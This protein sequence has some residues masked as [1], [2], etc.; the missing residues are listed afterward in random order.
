MIDFFTFCTRP[1]KL[2]SFYYYR[3][4]TLLQK[5]ESSSTKPVHDVSLFTS[6]RQTWSA[7]S[8]LLPCMAWL[9][10]NVIQSG[11]SIYAT[12]S[13][14]ICCKKG[15][16]WEV[17]Q[18]TSL[19]NSAMFRNKLQVYGCSNHSYGKSTHLYFHFTFY[20][21]LSSRVLYDQSSTFWFRDWNSCNLSSSKR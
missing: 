6:P 12:C 8:A 17:K 20:C 18:S 21:F 1:H 13:N 10:R 2:A 7:A 19:L 5:E 16:K 9:L 3:V 4:K 11:V 15:L 14:L